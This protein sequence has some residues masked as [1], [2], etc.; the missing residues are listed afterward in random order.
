MQS[1]GGLRFA[2]LLECPRFE[3]PD[4]FSGKTERLADLL[5]R[6]LF[7][8]AEAVSQPKDQLFARRQ[9]TDQRTDT[10]SH[11]VVVDAAIGLLRR[12]VRNEIFEPL[13]GTGNIRFERDRLARKSV[14]G[15][16]RIRVGPEC[17][18]QFRRRGLAT[19]LARE[20]ST[21]ALAALQ[22]VMNMRGQSDRPRVVLDRTNERLA[23]PPDGVG[24]VENLK[25]R[26]WSNFSTARIRPRLPS[27]IRSGKDRPRFR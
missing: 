22:P 21:H 16:E 4:A 8:T 5:E 1:L 19:Q 3:L 9:A 24:Q 15:F 13:F 2:Q 17:R 25:P 20:F 10:H 23:N 7:F 6:M 12:P 18:S 11:S 14:E 26:R 27:W